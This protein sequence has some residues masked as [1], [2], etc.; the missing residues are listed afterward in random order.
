LMSLT[1]R[2]HVDDADG[3]RQVV[4]DHLQ[5]GG[6]NEGRRATRVDRR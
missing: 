5:R 1:R 3:I 4:P 6:V 2:V